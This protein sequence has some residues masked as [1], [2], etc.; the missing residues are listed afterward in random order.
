MAGASAAPLHRSAPA[1]RL[2]ARSGADEHP[3]PAPAGLQGKGREGMPAPT[4]AFDGLSVKA[5]GNGRP[6]RSAV[7]RAGRSRAARPCR[8][9]R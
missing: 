8:G 6:A 3:E 4:A 5:T 1:P 7:T 2:A 9:G